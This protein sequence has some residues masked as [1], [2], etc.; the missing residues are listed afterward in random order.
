[1][2]TTDTSFRAKNVLLRA[3]HYPKLSSI[4]PTIKIH[5]QKHTAG[6]YYLDL[7]AP[8]RLPGVFVSFG[9][10]QQS[11]S[12]SNSCV[13]AQW[14]SLRR[15]NSSASIP[16][17]RHPA[18]VFRCGPSAV[19]PLIERRRERTQ[20]PLSPPEGRLHRTGVPRRAAND[21]YDG[22]GQPLFGLHYPERDKQSFAVSLDN[23]PK[24]KSHRPSFF[25]RVINS[26]L[27]WDASPLPAPLLLPPLY[28][29]KDFQL[30][31]RQWFQKAVKDH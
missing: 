19:R 15:P 11:N 7:R 20:H 31:C 13:L 22:P 5:P 26:P 2:N 12:R 21:P 9:V 30:F 25:T 4:N 23:G 24:S 8:S 18:P 28:S 16:N 3:I 17:E 10:P 27:C 6:I 14:D 29:P 1:M